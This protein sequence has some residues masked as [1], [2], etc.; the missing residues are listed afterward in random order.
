MNFLNALNKNNK[1]RIPIWFMRQ[2][3]RYLPEYMEIKNKSDFVTMSTTPDLISIITLQPAKRFDLDA[4]I[5]FSDI[6]TPLKP[7]GAFFKFAPG[8]KLINHGPDVLLSLDYLDPTKDMNFIK[9]AIKKIKKESKLPLIGFVGAPFTLASYV[10]EGGGFKDFRKTKKFMFENPEKF[11][12]ALDHL[13]TELS[14]YINFK[15]DC[16]VDAIQIFDSW[17]GILAAN[18]YENF[19]TPS[20][21]TILNNIKSIPIIFYTQPSM[22]LLPII[23]KF[24]IS[25]VSLDHR[26]KLDS[27]FKIL[28][29]N[30][31]D[32]AIQGNIDPIKM[33]L[34]FSKIKNEVEDILNRARKI[35]LD[36]FIFN[37]G[38]GFVPETNIDTI[39]DVIKTVH[40]IEL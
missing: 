12:K 29:D 34:E 36:R 31:A 5:I 23:S 4:L 22:H 32:F 14:K 2:A 24:K 39:K 17:G 27:A 28:I 16:G 37:V 10:I 25:A 33:T 9:D 35:G 19:V 13:A 30:G 7:M 20:V 18:D 6:L 15:I 38:Q 26:V 11:R 1:D 21:E 3:G 8:P 40:S